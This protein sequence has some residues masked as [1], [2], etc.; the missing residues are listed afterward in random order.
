MQVLEKLKLLLQVIALAIFC[1]QMMFALEKYMAGPTMT[2][3]EHRTL[4]SLDQPILL[5]ICKT[6]QFDVDLAESL[7]Y[8][9]LKDYIT[10]ATSN[11]SVLS[12]SGTDG[13]MTSTDI[14][15]NPSKASVSGV[16]NVTNKFLLP[17]GICSIAK[18]RRR[19]HPLC[20][21][22]VRGRFVL[23]MVPQLGGGREG[24]HRKGTLKSSHPSN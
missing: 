23:A 4:S 22:G 17:Y 12:W 24:A 5:A 19:W 2:A 21:M 9:S 18:G 11:E 16:E 14:I 7:G 3:G 13:N 20:G 10:G 15:I 6:S 8:T 1:V